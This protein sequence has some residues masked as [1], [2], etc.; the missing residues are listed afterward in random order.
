[1]ENHK[2]KCRCCFSKLNKRQ[3]NVK[4]TPLIE[5]TFFA[6]IQV[7]LRASRIYSDEI[8]RNCFSKLEKFAK[9]KN[10]AATKQ[11]ELYETY[12]DDGVAVEDVKSEFLA[13]DIK[14]EVI[15]KQE[16]ALDQDDR[17]D[18]SA[19][20]FLD[21][22]ELLRDSMIAMT[23]QLTTSTEA[24]KTKRA[25]RGKYKT[26]EAQEQICPDCGKVERSLTSMNKHWKRRHSGVSCVNCCLSV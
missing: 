4:I 1:M 13:L 19:E 14:Q 5:E 2:N 20:S 23:E 24:K 7:E 10:E 15:P 22:T 25:P 8:C 6:V 9:F 17:W 16:S 18:G 3:A 12:P 21:N 11:K 26:K